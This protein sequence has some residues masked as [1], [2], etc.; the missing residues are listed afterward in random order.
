MGWL[1]D[2]LGVFRDGPRDVAERM[3]GSLLHLERE[4]AELS[5]RDTVQRWLRELR[6]E[7]QT[8]VLVHRPWGTVVAV[9]DRAESVS[10][11]LSDGR[12]TWIAAAPGAT[13]SQPLTPEQIEYVLLDALTAPE[14]PT[15]AVWSDQA[16]PYGL[17]VVEVEGQEQLER[18]I[19]GDPAV[20]AGLTTKA[21]PMPGAFVRP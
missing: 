20:R 16:G 8:Q 13:D 19:A 14:R 2:R 11:F 4:R 15:W 9:A 3:T 6:P 12:R 17:G 18:L 1:R 5:D 7:H 21:Y 10:V